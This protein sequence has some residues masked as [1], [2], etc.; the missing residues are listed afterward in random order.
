MDVLPETDEG[1]VILKA[2]RLTAPGR[3]PKWEPSSCAVHE[4]PRLAVC[5][6]TAA[7]APVVTAG[8][9]LPQAPRM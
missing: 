1:E 2:C 3:R 4:S 9:A 7:T 5:D 8:A 6:R